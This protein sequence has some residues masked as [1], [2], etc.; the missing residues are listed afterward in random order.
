MKI[1]RFSM[2]R[3]AASISDSSSASCWT[4]A[5]RRS[6]SSSRAARSS[7]SWVARLRASV[8]AAVAVSVS[9]APGAQRVG[10]VTPVDAEELVHLPGRI[11]QPLLSQ[12]GLGEPVELLAG[13]GR[14]SSCSG[15]SDVEQDLRQPPFIDAVAD[16]GARSVCSSCSRPS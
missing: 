13:S 3:S 10:R 6:D 7:A 2:A 8:T 16:V 15:G 12:P 14:A 9:W 11:L 5:S 1:S 4:A